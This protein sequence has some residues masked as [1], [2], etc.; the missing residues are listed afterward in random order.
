MEEESLIQD[1][2]ERRE[3][4]RQGREDERKNA[5]ANKYDYRYVY[6]EGGVRDRLRY[7]KWG[8]ARDQG[9]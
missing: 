6:G 3:T 1:L 8:R 4:K 2:E 7:A 9:R 5:R